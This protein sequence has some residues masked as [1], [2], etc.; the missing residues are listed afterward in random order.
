MTREPLT[1][2]APLPHEL[3]VALKYLRK[4]AVVKPRPAPAGMQPPPGEA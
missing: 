1:I 3:A 2:Q 4:F